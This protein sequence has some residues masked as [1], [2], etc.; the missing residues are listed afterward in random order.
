[1]KNEDYLKL[2]AGIILIPIAV[3]IGAVIVLAGYNGINKLRFRK[4]MKKR[5]KEGNVIIIDGEFYEVKKNN[6]H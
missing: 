5:I 4:Q 1:M 3:N 6:N 2:V